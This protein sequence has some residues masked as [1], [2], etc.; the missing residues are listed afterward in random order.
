[1]KTDGFLRVDADS[2]GFLVNLAV[3]SSQHVGRMPKSMKPKRLRDSYRFRGFHPA[4]TVGG[5]FG[6]AYARVIQLTRR[7]KKRRAAFVAG[8][9]AGGMTP[10][11][12]VSDIYLLEAHA[13]FLSSTSVG[14]T[15]GA[16]KP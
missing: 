13:S 10:N 4:L 2:Q 15:A 5:L 9:R 1:M 12:A 8:C 16:A 7:S 3:T 6:D 14:S 11:C